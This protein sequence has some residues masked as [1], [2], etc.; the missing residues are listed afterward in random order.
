MKR[1]EINPM[2]RLEGHAKVAIFL[3]EGGGVENTYFQVPELRGFERFCQG[4]NAEEMPRIAPK[5]CGVCPVA[6]HVAA[7]KALD[8]LYDVEPTPTAEKLRRLMYNAYIF[9]DH[10]LHFY[11]LGG[12]DFL[13]GPDADP[14]DRNVLGVIRKVGEDVGRRVIQARSDAQDILEDVGGDAIQLVSCTAGGITKGLDSQ[15]I[16]EIRSR[17][18]SCFDFAKFTLD[19]FNEYVLEEGKYVDLINSD[20]YTLETHYM[21]LVDEHNEVDFYDGNVRVVNTRGDP[22]VKFEG[23]D[24]LDHIGERV[25]QSWTYLEFPFLKD[26]GWSGVKS[27]EDSGIYRV[28]PLA[29]LNAS[30]G[31]GTPVAQEEYERM[32]EVLGGGPVHKTLAYHWARLVEMMSAA[33][34]MKELSRD[35]D[36]TGEN[37]RNIPDRPSG[38]GIGVVEAARGTL[39]HHYKSDDDGV[40]KDVNLIVATVHN[41]GGI[42]MAIKKAAKGLIEGGDVSQGDLNRIEMAFRAHD[43][44]IACATHTLPGNMPMNLAIYDSEGNKVTGFSKNLEK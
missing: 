40:L 16:E 26:K 29:R 13:V 35:D 39:I 38:E 7:A 1:I 20:P 33:E 18:D 10:L 9:E 3:N 8:D 41:H 24:Y 34:R 23:E 25:D 32:F 12:P 44:C 37:I 5:I 31:V 43:P 30:D 15:E 6:H 36:I 11:Y 2:T 17:A 21:G 14:A 22:L 27:G 42:S 4:R 28:G 19:A